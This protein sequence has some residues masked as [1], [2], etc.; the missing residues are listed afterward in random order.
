M[1]FKDFETQHQPT[2]YLPHLPQ[3]S[4]TFQIFSVLNWEPTGHVVVLSPDLRSEISKKHGRLD[5]RTP[6]SVAA[7]HHRVTD[8]VGFG[9]RFR[10]VFGCFWMILDEKPMWMYHPKSSKNGF[11]NASYSGYRRDVTGDVTGALYCLFRSTKPP[12]RIPPILGRKLCGNWPGTKPAWDI[13]G[14]QKWGDIMG[15]KYHGLW[16]I[17]QLMTCYDISPLLSLYQNIMLYHDISWHKLTNNSNENSAVAQH[18]R[19][20]PNLSPSVA[21]WH[22][23][24]FKAGTGQVDFH[25]VTEA[26]SLQLL[27]TCF[28]CW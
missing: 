22:N 27:R 20:S 7:R 8:C 14:S 3:E 26:S 1:V 13:S 9:P 21:E 25:L 16:H 5:A 15:H 17:C 23:G 2:I 24:H 6:S 11:F 19:R 4:M 12:R 18:L 10:D 28:F